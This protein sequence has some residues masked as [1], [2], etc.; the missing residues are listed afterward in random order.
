MLEI[1][2]ITII[3]LLITIVIL[4]AWLYDRTLSNSLPARTEFEK[5]IA[6]LKDLIRKEKN[7]IDTED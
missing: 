3:I 4:N 1:L 5:E 2:L 7:K 6:E